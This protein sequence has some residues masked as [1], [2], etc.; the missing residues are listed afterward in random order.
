[1]ISNKL[2]SEVSELRSEKQSPKPDSKPTS[3][4]LNWM[5]EA[6]VAMNER[7]SDSYTVSGNCFWTPG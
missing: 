7:F 3:L 5:I 2:P 4:E 6:P 1:M